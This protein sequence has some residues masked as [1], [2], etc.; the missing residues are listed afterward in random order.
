MRNKAGKERTASPFRWM[1]KRY[2]FLAV[3]VTLIT[4]AMFP[5][6]GTMRVLSTR[7]AMDSFPGP[8]E[9][10]SRAF[11]VKELTLDYVYSPL[12]LEIICLILGG[13]GFGAAMVLFRHLFLFLQQQ[14]LQ[15]HPS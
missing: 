12:N 2:V 15:R 5:M 1:L 14:L 9:P 4:F 7:Q 8:V 3:A 10:Q 6:Q 11:Y 13:M